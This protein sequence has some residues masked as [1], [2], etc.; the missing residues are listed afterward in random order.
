[1][2]GQSPAPFSEKL[3]QMRK[4]TKMR[5]VPMYGLNTEALGGI[6]IREAECKVG[7]Y[8]R[9]LHVSEKGDLQLSSCSFLL[10]FFHSTP[11]L[12]TS[13]LRRYRLLPAT[14]QTYTRKQEKEIYAIG[15]NITTRFLLASHS[16][17]RTPTK[18]LLLAASRPAL[19][20]SSTPYPGSQ[21]T[22]AH[23]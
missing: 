13:P 23:E 5:P 11:R 14:P 7:C 20:S 17:E 1:M 21:S 19:Q 12:T 9:I 10:S 15:F 18:A 2:P 3:D 6:G 4:Y 16:F 22:Q 8:C